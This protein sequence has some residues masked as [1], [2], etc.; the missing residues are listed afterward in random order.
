MRGRS[1]AITSEGSSVENRLQVLRLLLPL[2]L[3]VITACA[4][5]GS[6]RHGALSGL[7]TSAS[8]LDLCEH[9]VPAETCVRCHPD[10]VAE[11]KKVN[12]W[13][14]EHDVPESQCLLCHPELSFE[15]LPEL[16]PNADIERLSASGEDVPALEPHSV[17]GKVT[18]FDFYADWCAPCRK[19]DAHVF[20]LMQ[21]RDDIALRKIN[22]V[23]WETPV[24]KR[25][26]AAV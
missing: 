23:S 26:L 2:S 20:T 7:T 1:Q 10:L 17:A 18:L 24:A 5:A 16:P 8:N 11:F 4:S 14:V 6:P 21:K 25:Y 22:V 9:R 19:I 3:A 12:D 13:C 15:A